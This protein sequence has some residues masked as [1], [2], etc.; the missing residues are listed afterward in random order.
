MRLRK[1]TLI[2]HTFNWFNIPLLQIVAFAFQSLILLPFVFN[3]VSFVLSIYALFGMVLIAIHLLLSRFNFRMVRDHLSATA[4]IGGLGMA[5]GSVIDH[6]LKPATVCRDPSI[7]AEQ[8]I[9]SYMMLGMLIACIPMCIRL[10]QSHYCLSRQWQYWMVICTS[11]IA[12]VGSMYISH[13]VNLPHFNYLLRD[14]SFH[15]LWMVIFMAT[16]NALALTGIT[17]LLKGELFRFYRSCSA[18]PK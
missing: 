10:C 4:S 3:S 1:P 13:I 15:H 11:V 9:F 14:P 16:F 7:G 6:L 18:R 5:L 8:W 12:M 2:D 17:V